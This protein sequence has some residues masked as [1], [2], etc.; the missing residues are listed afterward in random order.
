MAQTSKVKR[1]AG[2]APAAGSV[3]H[4]PHPNGGE[5]RTI[6]DAQAKMPKNQKVT[7]LQSTPLQPITAKMP[8][9]MKTGRQRDPFR[10]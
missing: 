4:K 10:R 5:N 3:T 6:A 1:E 7:P 2:G 8:K 9:T